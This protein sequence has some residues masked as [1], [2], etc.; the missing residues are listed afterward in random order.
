MASLYPAINDNEY[1][2]LKKIA[3]NTANIADDE[4]GDVASITGTANEITASAPTGAVTLSLPASLTFTGKT[5]T[6]GTYNSP[7]LVTPNIGAATGT[8]VVLT[9]TVTAQGTGSHVFGTTNTVTMAA[10]ALTATGAGTFVGANVSRATN[11]NVL[12]LSATTLMQSSFIEMTHSDAASAGYT[13]I[14]SVANGVSQFRVFGNGNVTQAGNLTV[15]G[16]GTS[17]FAGAVNIIKSSAGNTILA[18]IQNSGGNAGIELLGTSKTA[19]IVGDTGG[20]FRVY[21]NGTSGVVGTQAALFDAT[22]NTT[23]AGNLTVSGV[24]LAAD[25][26]A[27]APSRAFS[28][29]TNK[30]FYHNAT[31]EIGVAISG[32]LA[33]R[34]GIDGAVG[35]LLGSTVANYLA[36]A[37]GGAVDIVAAGTDQ[38]ITLTP[39]GTAVVSSYAAFQS[40]GSVNNRAEIKK[41]LYGATTDAATA[42]ELTTNG[43]V[44]SG[45]TNR[46]TVPNNTALSVVLN[47][48]VKQSGSANAKQ[49]LRQFVISNNG[50]VVAI[51][52]TVVTLGTDSGSAGLT[53]VTCTVTANDT[54]DAIKVE[55]NGVAATNLRYTAY[56]VSTEVVYV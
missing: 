10:G 3:N 1:S 12:D 21:T 43:A 18:S 13:F 46:I 23:L 27:A 54:D 45:A 17:S 28:T 36:L 26:T 44:G 30:G 55:V 25:G 52:G 32:T 5:I 39:S 2:L 49:M 31:N 20:A 29:Q 35:R 7:T 11:A 14:Q 22:Q 38:P 6:G 51:Q 47:I 37:P 9:G 33:L 41:V 15:S 42:V 48:S 50:G 4:L 40:Y 19:Y 16:T 34:F 8:S 53:T 24:M 56:L